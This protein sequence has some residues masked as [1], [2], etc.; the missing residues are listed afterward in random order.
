M[1]KLLPFLVLFCVSFLLVPCQ[2][3]TLDAFQSNMENYVEQRPQEKLHVHTDREIY[4]AGETIWYK[5]YATIGLENNLSIL[6]NIGY[7]E[8]LDPRW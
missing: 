8:L 4:G 1:R 3:Q 7:L 6:S 5:I 2:G